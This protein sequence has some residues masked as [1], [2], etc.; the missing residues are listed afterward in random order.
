MRTL[1]KY[2]I[3]RTTGAYGPVALGAATVCLSLPA[4]WGGLVNDDLLHRLIL[5][6]SPALD[7]V[8]ASPFEMFDFADGNSERTMMRVE[9]GQLPWW[10]LPELNY[11]FFRPVAVLTHCL[12]YALWPDSP[13]LMHLHSLLWAGLGVLF[14]ALLY[15]N[16][17]P[18]A[19]LAGL[20]AFLYA[21][22][23]AHALPIAGL[24]S[25]NALIG[26]VF[27]VGA[28]GCY[29]R[30]RRGGRMRFGILAPALL[31]AGLLANEG[32][33]AVCGYMS[34]YALFVDRGKP[35]SRLAALL[36]CAAAAVGW[37]AVY[38]HLGYGA[39]GALS[40]TDPGAF[41]ELFVQQLPGYAAYLFLGQWLVFPAELYVLSPAPVRAAVV[42]LALATG[43]VSF[44][45]LLPA[46]RREPVLRMFGLGMSIALI[47][48]CTALPDD[49]SLLFIGVGAMPLIAAIILEGLGALGRAERPRGRL[50]RYVA[51]GLLGIHGV[52]APLLLPLRAAVLGH[53]GGLA[54]DAVNA[55]ELDDSAVPSQTVAVLNT[56]NVGLVPA[57][58]TLRAIQGR[59]V[60]RSVRDLGPNFPVEPLR[61]FRPDTRTLAV[62]R[63]GGFPHIYFR[64]H[65]AFRYRV[66]DVVRLEDVEITIVALTAEGL[67][68]QVA[69]RFDVPLEDPSL[70]LLEYA[71]GRLR[72]FVPPGV[73]ATMVVGGGGG[74]PGRA[75]D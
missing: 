12:D 36:P 47:P 58:N 43:A 50:L 39:M 60:P 25:R 53:F 32:A 44:R 56:P 55:L 22:D 48:A 2:I 13:W 14:V 24:A 72:P 49:R 61:V 40:H 74:A 41:P 5:Q 59:P 33:V 9:W 35:V 64:G 26:L 16:L 15:R 27:G 73:G 18:A 3:V 37:R 34:G 52:L 10:T 54:N 42:V 66:G 1:W 4:L 7:G 68:R 30:W 28:L 65:P 8:Y 67:P 17:L 45:L 70:V 63:P 46:L 19:P 21:V 23:D 38:S 71:G 31:L 11:N 62:T 20:A 69:Y 57:L 29:V 51:V 6:H 75:V